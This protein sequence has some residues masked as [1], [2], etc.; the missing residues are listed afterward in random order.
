MKKIL[1]LSVLILS[2]LQIN[3]QVDTLKTVSI[4]GHSDEGIQ[5]MGGAE[6]GQM[7]GAGELK[8]AAC[9]NLGESFVT[10]PSVDV[11]Y[12]DAAVGAKQIKLLGLSGLYV[13]M[14]TENMANLTG[15]ATPYALNYVP[16]TWM[17]S[18]SIS[19]GASAV[20]HGFQSITGQ[21]DVEYLKP[22]EPS[23][24]LLNFYT[25][26]KQ[27]YEGNI[28]ASRRF[29]DKLSTEVLA[30]YEKDFGHLDHD[31]DLWHDLPS[32]EQI[33]LSN[34]WKY[35]GKRYIFHGGFGLLD[36]NREGGQL[37]N[38][39]LASPYRILLDN[40]RFDAHM[41]HAII[42][43][44]EHN[45]NIA[46]IAAVNHF[47]LNGTFGNDLYTNRHNNLDTRLMF[48]HDFNYD[49]SIST[50]L[51][52]K[53]DI[54]EEHLNGNDRPYEEMVPGAYI[55]YT[56]TPSFR[57][58]A[59]AGF[60]AD[61]SN[62]YGAFA[63]PRLHLKWVAADWLTLRG[64]VGKGYRVPFALAENHY[65]LASGR[66]LSISDN[67]QM[68]EAW[69]TGLSAAFT[70][71]TTGKKYL[72]INYEEYYTHFLN[73]AVIN[74]DRNPFAVII[75]NLDGKSYSHTIQID[76]N[77]P[78]VYK[79]LDVTAAF[80]VNDVRCTYD[81]ELRQA[82][83]TSRM[84]GLL[85]ATW[86]PRMELWQIDLT[87]QINGGGRMPDPYTLEDGTLSWNESFPAYPMLNAQITRNFRHYSLY[88]GGENLTN[89]RQ[90]NPIINASN[91]WSESFDPTMIWGPMHGIMGYI[92][93][94]ANLFGKDK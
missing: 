64:S 84:K 15:A 33:N 13:Q 52:F 51:S 25:D 92:G 21:I 57:F 39:G 61:Y 19:K 58:T 75:D 88:I 1:L 63:T 66:E 5:R 18:I 45:S 31:G 56:Y 68:E 17:R 10:N 24:I 43:N 74:F 32:V 73:Q 35:M 70:F 20:K 29:T 83:L 91:P 89:Y 54:I 77:Y 7:M 3:A 80:R 40:R 34:R 6:N 41:K 37:I 94:R 78:I 85:T 26:S 67:L 90:P 53:G 76:A 49:H 14:L 72:K 65:L 16:G 48:E 60:R 71:H 79:K 87:L 46:L 8:R 30:H 22:D 81:G 62:L 44:E 9:C 28:V 93:L 55:Q 38:V 27:K 47:E 23:G 82:P 42:L 2:A 11:N 86:K 4:K 59:M 69:N 12:S 50:G 36:E